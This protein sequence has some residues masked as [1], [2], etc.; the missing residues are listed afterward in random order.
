MLGHFTCF[1]VVLI[2]FNFFNKNIFDTNGLDPDQG[3]LG[4]IWIFTVCKSYQQGKSKEGNS[5]NAFW[6]VSSDW[7][8]YRCIV[9]IWSHTAFM[10]HGIGSFANNVVFFLDIQGPRSVTYD[11]GILDAWHFQNKKN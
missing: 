5:W 3:H 8:I 1:F 7:M 4:L 2:F 9:L 6:H 11:F 10:L